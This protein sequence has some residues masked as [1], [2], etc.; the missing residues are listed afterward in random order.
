MRGR[1]GVELARAELTHPRALDKSPGPT[2]IGIKA[3]KHAGP[4]RAH[5]ACVN[6]R[7]STEPPACAGLAEASV[8]DRMRSQGSG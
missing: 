4:R 8:R 7:A 1:A 6:R 3:T 5:T 2:R